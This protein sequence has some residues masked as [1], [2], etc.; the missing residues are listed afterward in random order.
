LVFCRILPLQI[1]GMA[2]LTGT[3]EFTGSMGSVSA[4]RMRGV[5]KIV[6]RQKGGPGKQ[7][8]KNSPA[9]ELTRRYN[10]ECKGR[11]LLVKHINLAMQGVRHLYDYNCSGDMAAVCQQVQAADNSNPLGSRSV[12][13]SQA[14]F[15][16][17]GFTINKYQPFD[18]VVKYP[19][20]AA[21]HRAS[22]TASVSLPELVPGLH[23]T[24]PKQQPLYRLVF[25]LG[26]VPDI[27]Y[28]ES[29]KAYRP[30]PQAGTGRVVVHTA[31]YTAGENCPAQEIALQLTDY[32]PMEGQSLLVSAGIEYGQPKTGGYVQGTKYA[33][34]A[35]VLKLG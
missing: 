22:G 30:L 35:K 7:Q 5:D 17:E 21:I 12:L 8:I 33:G 14:G 19:L 11:M 24:N 25:V 10:E 16:L 28:D 15:L 18:T 20:A 23:I 9:F 6:L 26:L 29:W 4:Y 3:M 34:A 31:W 32:Q 27:I 1:Q 2:K 13:L